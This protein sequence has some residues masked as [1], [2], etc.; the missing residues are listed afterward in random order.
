MGLSAREQLG[1]WGIGLAAFIAFLWLVGDALL[2]F[3]AGAAIAYLLDPI[4]G[5]LTAMGMSRLFA[6]IL[7][8]AAMLLFM[9]LTLVILVPLMI[10]QV[11]VLAV[12]LPDSF[13]RAQQ[14]LQ[15]H[16]PALFDA[17]TPL[18]EALADAA[19]SLRDRV[20]Q[21]VNNMLAGGMAVVDFAILI[22]LAPVIAFYLLMDWD[23]LIHAIDDWLPREHAP[24][25]RR[26][27]GQVDDVLAGFVRGQLT[28]CTILGIFYAVSLSLVGLQFGLVIGVF[29]G[30]ISFI[31][32]VGAIL[33]GV[34]SVGVALY[35]FWGDPIYILV[36]ASIFGAGQALEG[37]L[38]T[39]KLVGDSV[40]LHPVWLMFALATF[41]SLMGF[42]GMLVAVPIAA[43]IGVLL[44][45]GIEQY[46]GS[47]LYLGA[48]PDR[49][50]RSGSE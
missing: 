15:A 6:T 27:A 43:V 1:Y 47:R 3:I 2:P 16:L 12:T 11:R 7:I 26:L 45:F 22:L 34:L 13:D 36:T 49:T 46:K 48:D 23:R 18:R 35:Q 9:T 17:G 14:A 29:A 41:G 50:S 21:L 32:F 24:V 4:A 8:T 25:I 20:P 30:V 33:G 38:L 39:P 28:V 42:T 5:R 44:R 19:Q 40:G 31:P 10:D 37:N